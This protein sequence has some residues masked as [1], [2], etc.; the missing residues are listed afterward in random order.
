M[1]LMA[2]MTARKIPAYIK[3][4]LLKYI[5]FTIL[6]LIKLY[7]EIPKHL[8]EQIKTGN[9]VLFLGAGASFGATNMNGKKIPLGNDL[10]DL[11]VEK[12]L[13]DD[14]K[15]ASLQHVA[16]LCTSESD[17][18]DVQKYIYEIFSGFNPTEFHKLIPNF[19]WRAIFTVNYD[20]TIERAYD[21]NKERIQNIVPFIKNGQKV[22]DQIKSNNDLFYIKLHG[23]ISEAQN[24]EIPLILSP[25]QYIDH[26]TNR[27]RLFDKLKDYKYEN[28][29]LFVGFSF[30]DVDI[31]TIIKQTF[32]SHENVPR[33]YLIGPYIK[34]EEAKLWESKKIS[35]LKMSFEQFL[36]TLNSQ[37]SIA[38]R[39]LATI[40]SPVSHP[41]INK[42]KVQRQDINIS[43]SLKSFLELDIEYVYSNLKS[44]DT[45]PKNF[46]KGYFNNWDPIIKNMDCNRYIKDNLLLEIF[47]DEELNRISPNDFYL[48]KGQAGSGKSV[49]LKRLA[50]DAAVDFDKI[51]LFL[52]DD[53]KLRY[54]PINE[55]YY[56]LKDRIYL[57]I[58]N[59]SE[60]VNDIEEIIDKAKK[61]K[62]L[63]TIICAE[64]Y[65]TWNTECKS[66][67]EYVTVEY[68]L[69]YLNDKEI[70]ELLDLL[71]KNNSLGYLTSKS[72]EERIK[73]LSE[74]AGRQ[75]LV[76]LHEA[77]Q[78]RPFA[79]IVSKE[80]QSISNDDA[81]QLYLTIAI[82]HR[83][84]VY[85][86][87]GL[88][89][90]V[91]NIGFSYFKEHLFKPLENIV[92][93]NWKY[94]IN[95]YALETRHQHIAEILFEE[96][97]RNDEDRYD[98]MIR[99]LNNLDIDYESDRIAYIAMIKAK[100]LKAIFSNPKYVRLIYRNIREDLKNDSNLFLQEAIFEMNSHDGDLTR[101]NELLEEAQELD[102]K[103]PNI[104][105]SRAEFY[106]R[107]FETTDNT[108]K[109][110][111]YLDTIKEIC[112]KL[113]SAKN[114][115]AYPYH[116]LLKALVLDIKNAVNK[117]ALQESIESKIKDF[118]KNLK[119]AKRDFPLESYIADTE[120]EFNTIISE[121]PRA[122]KIL[123]NAFTANPNS[124]YIAIRLCKFYNKN[125]A[126]DKAKEVL[127]KCLEENP[128]SKDLN[129]LYST[130]L[131]R[132]ANPDYI[133]IKH[134][135]RKSFTKNDN[136][137]EE[138]FLYGRC[139]YILDE[140]A[141]YNDV[142]E[143][144]STVKFKNRSQV[145]LILKE[146][147]REKL[148]SGV[149]TKIE[150]SFGFIKRDKTGDRLFFSKSDNPDIDWA[151][152]KY[153]QRVN[154]NIGFNFKGAVAVNIIF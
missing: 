125:N 46:Y 111:K 113:N 133:D 148:F 78:G 153:N 48:I 93:Y 127:R 51:C 126:K 10:R 118:E 58:D 121:H 67:E 91:H 97:L 32:S 130:F 56:Y 17:L 71:E 149:I 27:D 105:H 69:K 129:Y 107:K 106:L 136:N 72:K 151:K 62:I 20:L 112:G 24:V 81:K 33:S 9:V 41:I 11:L 115:S 92:F 102:E 83:L 6:A 142:F 85:T 18:L 79:E 147:N 96:V 3:A 86:R 38:D 114:K 70:I 36:N 50:W 49:L 82:L 152:F 98:K 94:S 31:R 23:C 109:Q 137:H 141:E 68:E 54:E 60:H 77:T 8:L 35:S 7:M 64:R 139:C 14:F 99:I 21:T 4:Y 145:R 15:N 34:D 144:L 63:L 100:N 87:V 1:L 19:R 30:D 16:E 80:Y 39:K 45:D 131:M 42:F 134:Y 61:D 25:E 110:K 143:F 138:Q 95:D 104:L 52:N 132:E 74:R 12:Y 84:G 26:K 90:R 135:L 89:S 37:I 122:L 119:N 13:S 120:A 43:E 108:V 140:L 44:K 116:T 53:V 76:A 47:L 88:I 124:V 57:F 29:F 103:N 128:N 55:L 117:D 154:F 66:L 2:V 101:A 73:E 123:E 40:L 65:S 75:L 146:N 150:S 22:N 28:P 59:P 5:I